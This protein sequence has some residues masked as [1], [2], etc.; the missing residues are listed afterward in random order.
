MERIL[1]TVTLN[2]LPEALAA[3]RNEHL[4]QSLYDEGKVIMDGTLL[5]LH[6][7]A[8]RSRRLLEFRVFRRSFFRFYETQV[9]PRALAELM[10]DT[11]KSGGCDLVQ[12]GFRITMTLRR[13]LPGSTGRNTR[14]PKRLR[15]SIWSRH[16]VKAQ[17]WCTR[18]AIRVSC[19]AR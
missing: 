4:A 9:F 6:G 11:V 13:I 7:A 3:L 14:L 5:T 19:A 10:G 1:S 12:F 15:C 8:H 2:R 17:P 16:S 18:H